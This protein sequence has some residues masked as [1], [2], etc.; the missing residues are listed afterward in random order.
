MSAIDGFP[1]GFL[2]LIVPHG[3]VQHILQRT[4]GPQFSGAHI[5]QKGAVVAAVGPPVFLLPAVVTGSAVDELF[6]PG[7]VLHAPVH[8]AIVL[9]TA[10]ILPGRLAAGDTLRAQALNILH[11]EKGG[12][13][14]NVGCLAATVAG[15]A[16]YGLLKSAGFQ[17]VRVIPE[18]GQAQLDPPLPLF[19][20]FLQCF[21]PGDGI[22]V[23][24]VFRIVFQRAQPLEGL[25]I[26]AITDL[27]EQFIGILLEGCL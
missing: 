14:E 18:G 1:D 25:F 13:I 16:I 6:Q 24:P 11:S 15:D 22:V 19:L 20:G 21:G 2:L 17:R 8:G 9:E 12:C 4:Q 23:A 7:R 3:I 5:A 10:V 26:G 27:A